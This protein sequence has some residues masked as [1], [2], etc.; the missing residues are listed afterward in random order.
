M[1]KKYCQYLTIKKQKQNILKEGSIILKTKKFLI[2]RIRDIIE[3]LPDFVARPANRLSVPSVCELD[4]LFSG[5]LQILK[6]NDAFFI[7]IELNLQ[8]TAKL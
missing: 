2:L 7:I 1:N 8:K 4:Q 5:F 3:P 6:K